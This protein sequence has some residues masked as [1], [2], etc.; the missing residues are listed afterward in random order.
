[1]TLSHRSLTLPTLRPGDALKPGEDEIDGLKRQL[2]QKLAPMGADLSGGG[3]WEVGELLAVWWRPNF[4]TYMVGGLFI[5]R[6]GCGMN[7]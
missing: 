6:W 7:F 5:L 4:E 1:M 2:N 3:D